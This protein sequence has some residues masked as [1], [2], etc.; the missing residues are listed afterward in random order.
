MWCPVADPGGGRPFHGAACTVSCQLLCQACS[1]W[2]FQAA[3]GRRCGTSYPLSTAMM[4]PYRPLCIR[5]RPVHGLWGL[6]HVSVAC[7]VVCWSSRA[8]WPAS[9]YLHLQDFHLHESSIIV[10]LFSPH[11]SKIIF[12]QVFAG[13]RRTDVAIPGAKYKLLMVRFVG[14]LLRFHSHCSSHTTHWC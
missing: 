10:F 2:S 11:V 12:H 9:L 13:W 3:T 4:G 1:A 7:D 8:I 5:C 6:Q 14:S